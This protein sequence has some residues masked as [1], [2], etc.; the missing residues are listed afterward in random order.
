MPALAMTDHG[1]LCAAPSF[2]HACRAAGIEPLLG[3]EFYFAPDASNRETKERN[4]VT[5]LAKGEQ[6]YKTLVELS[7]A[8]FRKFWYKPLLDKETL[9]SLGDSAQHLVVLSGCAASTISKACIEGNQQLAREELLWWREIFP[10]FYLEMMHHDTDFDENLNLQLYKLAKH[11]KVPWAITNDPHYAC[12]EDA[13]AHDTLLA[14]QTASDIDDPNRLRFDG[15]G[16]HLRSYK[17]MRK[18][19]RGYPAELWKQGYRNTMKISK[20]ARLRIPQWEKRTW[21]IPNFP[22][23]Q[24]DSYGEL[25]RLVK[26]GLKQRQLH[27]NPLYLERVQEELR[28]IKKVG[29]A[30]FL[31]ITWDSI[32]WAREQGIPVGPGRGSVCG[33]LVGYLIGLHK[34][35][36]VRYDLLFER[37]LNPARPRMP[38]IDTDFGQERREELFTYVSDKYG[39]ENVVHVATYHTM[40]ARSAFQS[41]A[42][43]FGISWAERIEISK[44]FAVGEEEVEDY[45][46]DAVKEQYPELAERITRLSGIKKSVAAHPA[47]VIIADPRD[48]IRTLVPLMWIPTTKRWV[49]QYDLEAVEDMGLMKQDFLGLRTLDTINECMQLI[50]E[51]TGEEIQPDE[52]VPDLEHEDEELYAMLALGRTA[53]V[54]QME[55]ATNTRGCREVLPQC[56]EDIVSIT[57]LYRTGPISAGFPKAFVTNRRKGKE[58]IRYLHPLLKPI[59]DETWGVIL[60]QE[61]VMKIAAEMAGF[62]MSQVD[63][64]KEAIKHKR[65]ELMQEM[66]PLFIKGCRKH[67]KVDEEVAARI[68]QDIEG[69]SGYSYNRSHAVA[70]SFISYQTARLK[71]LYPREYFAALLRTIPSSSSNKEKR[72]VYLREATELGIKILPPCA[73]RSEIKA[74]VDA[75]GIRLGI[76]DL[77]KIGPTQ[78]AK[79]LNGRPAEGYSSVAQ[80]VEACNNKG[81]STVLS[82]SGALECLGVPYEPINQE[83]LTGWAFHDT[84]KRYRKKYQQ[85][86][87]LPGEDGEGV[88]ILGEISRKDKG[89][90]KSGKPYM[91]WKVRHSITDCYDVRLWQETERLWDMKVGSVVMI[92]GTW[93]QRWLNVSI[94]DPDQVEVIKVV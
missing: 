66:G 65:S 19:F 46:P 29:I 10:H 51:S 33:T 90:T 81:V 61:Q 73:N 39:E 9:E 11:F 47:G 52:W 8:A 76:A 55:G 78:A 36:P 38:D 32:R 23:A 53:G 40:K 79:L 62:T 6:G 4:H 44:Q 41:C 50:K 58:R 82:D 34:M 18:A 12:K 35:D 92:H 16:Y 37:F 67:S 56:F 94:S 69:Y 80:V 14:I 75:E 59:L 21:H 89:K 43:A 2:Y 91:T 83:A 88:R 93:E 31:L 26:V 20:M 7:T 57:S 13:V 17:E 84:M 5:I 45:F 68:W 63:D 70:Y 30:D 42:K 49:G 77:A 87:V 54:F 24:G 48:S 27:K 15:R 22:D 86:V 25:K 60:Y 71:H 3:Q 64:I 85:Q 28:A 72:D 1:N 74:T